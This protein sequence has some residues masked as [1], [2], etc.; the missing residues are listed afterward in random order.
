MGV[1]GM[2]R[3][4]RPFLLTL[5]LYATFIVWLA[6]HG[7]HVMY[8]GPLSKLVSSYEISEL[9]DDYGLY[10][11][12]DPEI[13]YYNR[14][15]HIDDISTHDANDLLIHDDFSRDQRKSVMMN[16]GAV[17]MKNILSQNTSSRLR[18]Y[19][20]RRHDTFIKN[21]M[22]LPWNE[23]FWNGGDG[24]RL[25][26]GIGPEDDPIIAQA[27][28][29]VGH[30]RQLEE[31][32]TA[33][34]G[35]NPALVEVSTLTTM[36][37]ASHQGIHTD[38]D[39]FGSSV[40]YARTF[41]H[42]YTMFVALQDT[43]GKMGATTLCPGTHFCANEDLED[44]C[45][46][47]APDGRRNSFE[48]SSNGPRNKDP[49][50]PYNR[51]MF[52]LTFV[53]QRDFEKGDVRQQGWGTYYYMRHSMWGQAFNDLKTVLKGGMS[54]PI[55]FL[56][57]YGLY[58]TP[59]SG[60]GRGMPWLEHWARQMANEMDF[61]APSE[62][63]AFHEML[64]K[65]SLPSRILGNPTME[66]WNQ[67]LTELVDN[68][69][70]WINGIYLLVLFVYF[71]IHLVIASFSASTPATKPS[72]NKKKKKTVTKN[73]SLWRS[74]IRFFLPLA[75]G[76]MVVAGIAVLS[77]S[78]VMTHAPLFRRIG[79]GYIFRKPFPILDDTSIRD[80]LKGRITTVPDRMD[81][82]IGSRYDAP[83]LR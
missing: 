15:C 10:M 69:V 49:D 32:L 61:F 37:G 23:L 82:L 28:H 78:Y 70:E 60:N 67:Y 30:N 19:L 11:A 71:I 13:T 57:A 42:S 17:V 62:L 34:V 16:H 64:Q 25:S 14:Q 24:S 4:L 9:Q 41:L 6:I 81:V 66:D 47:P 52:I 63:Q 27:L 18:E 48:A 1:V 12:R 77:F 51:A 46:T 74:L 55:R 38:S 3:L 68:A 50:R 43:T 53:S 22:V 72:N 20:E 83:Y 33:I 59:S 29:E 73:P 39:Y 56:K 7:L 40:L 44:V 31:T 54:L 58:S 26:L 35:P 76:H 75:I 80:H 45:M 65:S 2:F 8:H 21:D 36:H 5:P 79:M